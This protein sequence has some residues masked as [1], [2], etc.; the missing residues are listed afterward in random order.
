MK[1]LGLIGGMSWESSAHYYRLINQGVRDSRRPTASAKCLLWS[2][3]FAEIE[4]LQHAGDWARLEALMCDAGQRLAGAGAEALVI[5]TNTMHLMAD[6]VEAAAGVPLLH[7]A[8][9]TGA[10][11]RT[12]GIE[13]IGLLGTAFTME[14]AFYKDR[15]TQHHGLE[16]LVPE[17]ED[18]A[19]VHRV[20]YEELVSGMVRDASR[21]AYRQVIARLIQ[22]GAQGVI[23]GCTEI[24]L[25]VS[26]DDAAVPLFDTTTLHAQAAVQLALG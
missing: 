24:M 18:R 1:L 15:L 26:Q 7:I 12:A 14:Q 8:D 21:E 19:L 3:D 2:F 25:L 23:L 11:V 16:V 10:A 6:R 9:P 22:R 4:A 17:P 5:C 20:I 13:R